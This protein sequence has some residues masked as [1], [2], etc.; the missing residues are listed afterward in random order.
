MGHITVH[1]FNRMGFAQNLVAFSFF[2]IFAPLCLVQKSVQITHSILGRASCP[3][4]SKYIVH[5]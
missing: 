1:D 3:C 4:E 5:F 2:N